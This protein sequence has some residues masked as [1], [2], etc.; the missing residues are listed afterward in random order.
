MK[1][2]SNS[3]LL[4][5]REVI[6]VLYINIFNAVSSMPVIQSA[7]NTA[8]MLTLGNDLMS[9]RQSFSCFCLSSIVFV[10]YFE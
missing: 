2:A 9:L 7:L 8:V 1:K 6:S 10:S 3:E 5:C 4:L